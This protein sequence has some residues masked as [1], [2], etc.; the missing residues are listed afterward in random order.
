MEQVRE[1]PELQYLTLREVAAALKVTPEHVRK[2]CIRYEQGHDDGLG[3]VDVGIGG[4]M[5]K[6]RR[7]H[8]DALAAFVKQQN[9]QARRHDRA[10][11]K[12]DEGLIEYV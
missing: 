2:L 10:A 11:R 7:V 3:C 4:G 9:R 8:V 6:Q 12:V 5:V 1:H